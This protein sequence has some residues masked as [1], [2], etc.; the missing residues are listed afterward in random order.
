MLILVDTISHFLHTHSSQSPSELHVSAQCGHHQVL[1]HVWS[2]CTVIICTSLICIDT[3]RDTAQNKSKLT[4]LCWQFLS[5]FNFLKTKILL[6]LTYYFIINWDKHR[7]TSM[8]VIIPVQWLQTCV[9]EP[10]DGHIALKHVVR[11]KTVN[12]ERVNSDW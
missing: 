11:K 9:L 7:G 3:L 12:C 5:I 8:Y 10:D 1:I 2:H 6:S 4:K